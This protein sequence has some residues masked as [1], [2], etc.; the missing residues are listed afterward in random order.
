MTRLLARI[1]LVATVALVPAS[2][3]TAES[4]AEFYKGKTINII[5]GA[6]PGGPYDNLARTF[7]QH[8]RRFIPGNPTMVPQNMAGASSLRAAEYLYNVAPRNGTVLG[9]LQS[10]IILDKLI[11]PTE[12]IEP[13]KLGW[14]GRVQPLDN[15]G[16]A[17]HTTGVRTIAEARQKAIIYGANSGI[18]TTSIIPWALNR[19]VG[20]RFNVIPGYESQTTELLAMERGEI[21]GIGSVSMADL[22]AKPGWIGDK[23]A[24]LY[25]TTASRQAE[26]PEV[27]AIP[28]LAADE[29]GRAVLGVLASMSDIGHTVAAPPGVPADR[30]QAL[31]DAFARLVVD[32]SFV[33]EATRRGIHVM[34]RSAEEITQSVEQDMSLP[35]A[36]VGALKALTVAPAAR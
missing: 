20:T 30:L 16:I 6:G 9:V 19:F 32:P 5:I 25:T 11:D 27:P 7:A 14:L 29:A 31:R 13:Q 28:E 23:I 22:T 15:V 4:V 21:E 2:A 8:V 17:W 12:K 33:E 24:V 3:A 34:P 1:G 36:M 35:P 26:L 10:M 18:G